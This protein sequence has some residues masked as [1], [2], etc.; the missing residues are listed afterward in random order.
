VVRLIFEPQRPCKVKV[1]WPVWRVWRHEKAE[2]YVCVILTVWSLLV[3]WCTTSLTF[4]NCTLYPHCIYVF[5]IYLRTNSDL[6]HLQHELIGFYNRDEKFL[7][8]GTDCV[9]KYSSLGFVFKRLNT[10]LGGYE[11]PN[12]SC[13]NF[14]SKERTPVTYWIRGWIGCRTRLVALEKRGISCLCRKWNSIV[15]TGMPVQDTR[16]ILNYI[17]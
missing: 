13:G 1:K 12:W 3:T 4:N 2:G 7:L 10:A 8:R 14:T 16:L 11:W 5:C 9:F 15:D 17:L 6:C